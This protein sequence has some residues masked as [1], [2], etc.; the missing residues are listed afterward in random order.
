MSGPRGHTHLDLHYLLHGD[1]TDPTPPPDESQ[2]V[3]WYSW[4]E[5]RR[6]AGPCMTGIVTHLSTMH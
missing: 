4:G 3:A 5:A 2:E 6:V 1:D